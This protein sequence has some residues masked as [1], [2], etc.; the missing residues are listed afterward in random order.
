ML[1]PGGTNPLASSIEFVF[2]TDKMIVHSSGD[3]TPGKTE[4]DRPLSNGV[5]YSKY[6]NWDYYLGIFVPSVEKKTKLR[7]CIQL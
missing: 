5:D 4:I 6:E 2:P 3:D 7:R 1:T